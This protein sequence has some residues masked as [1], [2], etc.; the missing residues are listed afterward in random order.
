MSFHSGDIHYAFKETRLNLEPSSSANVVN[1][2]IPPA[3]GQ[4]RTSASSYGNGTS[5]GRRNGGSANGGGGGDSGATEEEIAFRRR[6]L[7]TESSVFF[8]PWHDSP[9]A[10]LWRV[11][12][13]DAVLSVRAA[14]VCRRE[15]A[16][17]DAPLVLNFRFAAPLRPGCVAFA[18]SRE[19]DVVCVFALDA[20]NALHAIHLRP[21]AFR[22]RS[23]TEGPGSVAEICRSYVPAQLNG[24]KHPHRLVAASADELVVTLHDGGI[25]RLDRNKGHDGEFWSGAT[26]MRRERRRALTLRAWRSG[27][28]PLEGDDQ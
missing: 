17:S 22:K 15:R 2:R 20:A 11:L 26:E 27:E 12:E 5:G 28:P 14:D 13:D 3:P 6:N 19:H 1:I 18:D 21:E 7:A 9:R 16:G 8:R 25:I 23:V 10:V 24:F 4:G